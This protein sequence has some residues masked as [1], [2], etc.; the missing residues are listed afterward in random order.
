MVVESS[1]WFTAGSSVIADVVAKLSLF[2]RR[3]G[4]KQIGQSFLH[5]FVLVKSCLLLVVVKEVLGR[6]SLESWQLVRRLLY[7]KLS[8]SVI[9][10]GR[11]R[12]SRFLALGDVERA[13]FVKNFERSLVVN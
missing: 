8:R 10:E 7:L 11:H 4:P 12:P 5:F 9:G 2:L 1:D 3:Y 13:I 6:R